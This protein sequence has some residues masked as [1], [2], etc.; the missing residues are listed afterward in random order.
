MTRVFF[1]SHLGKGLTNF[2]A[3][4]DF[5]PISGLPILLHQWWSQYGVRLTSTCACSFNSYVDR[6]LPFF[7]PPPLRALFLYPEGGQ[8]Q[9]FFDP[10]PI[11]YT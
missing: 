11:L 5:E 2:N 3:Q 9:T 7:D 8:K 1:P 10:S 4:V 6:I